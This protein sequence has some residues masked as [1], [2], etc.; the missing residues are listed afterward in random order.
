MIIITNKNI[1]EQAVKQLKEYGKVLPFETKWI[2]YSAISGHP[3][4]FF[5]SSGNQ[6]IIAPNT[7]VEFKKVLNENHVSY[8]EGQSEVGNKYPKNAV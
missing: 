2:T 7:S 5:C 4:V 1:P 6:L 8:N 3:D